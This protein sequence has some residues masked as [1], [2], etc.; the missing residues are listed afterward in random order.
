MSQISAVA[1]NTEVTAAPAS[2]SGFRP[3][4]SAAVAK[5]NDSG[6]FGES[7]EVTYSFDR[8]THQPVV[9]VLDTQTKEVINQW[10]PAFA[11]KLASGE[12]INL[13]GDS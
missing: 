4:V 10:P 2:Q 9:R 5:L 11:L 1:G 12:E 3:E 8:A 6:F 7:R 13:R